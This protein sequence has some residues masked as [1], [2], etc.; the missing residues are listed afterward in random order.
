MHL[1]RLDVRAMLVGELRFMEHSSPLEGRVKL[2]KN[3]RAKV[4]IPDQA[5][6]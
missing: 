5:N 2:W 4:I 1:M 6:H 3:C